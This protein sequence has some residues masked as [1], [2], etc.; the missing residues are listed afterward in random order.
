M[1]R[2]DFTASWLIES[3]Q[4][5]PQTSVIVGLTSVIHDLIANGVETTRV[6][7]L[8]KI[9]LSEIVYYW[10]SDSHNNIVLAAE[11]GKKPQTLVVHMLGKLHKGAPPFASDLYLAVLA[12]RKNTGAFNSIC[13]TSDDMLSDDGFGVWKR[14]LIDGHTISVYNKQNTGQNHTQIKTV[15]EL[16]SLFGDDKTHKQYQFILS[17]TAQKDIEVRAQFHTRRLRELGGMI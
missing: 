10:Q 16:E 8:N 5:I 12:D 14:L 9:E 2:E 1:S 15:S 6:G 7:D 3:P 13:L 4:R 11:F 17:E